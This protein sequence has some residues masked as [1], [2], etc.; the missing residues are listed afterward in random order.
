MT[1]ETIETIDMTATPFTLAYSVLDALK[2]L[3][4]APAGMT[5]HV[6]NPELQEMLRECRRTY[7]VAITA[8]IT[9]GERSD[10]SH[11]AYDHMRLVR[12]QYVAMCKSIGEHPGPSGGADP[13]KIRAALGDAAKG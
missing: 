10:E 13:M 5:F 6:G 8:K 1:T 7:K 12:R 11:D 9:Y 4:P 2:G 3:K